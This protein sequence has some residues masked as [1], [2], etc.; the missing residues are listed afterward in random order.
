TDAAEY[1]TQREAA[2]LLHGLGTSEALSRL[3][4]RPRH[5][6]ARALLRDTRWDAPQA[7]A[8]PLLGEPAAIAAASALVVL[9]LRRAIR[10]AAARWAGAS[11]GGALA[12]LIAGA[13]GGLILANSPGSAAPTVIVVLAVVGTCA[14]G[15]G[16]AG[17]GAGLAAAEAVARS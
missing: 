4:T 1:E 10:I 13:T 7:G 14:G 17:V 15:L 5:S 2:E 16:G 11:I 8:V 9:R 6:F 3:G 12:G